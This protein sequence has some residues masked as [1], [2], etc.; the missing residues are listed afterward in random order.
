MNEWSVPLHRIGKR[1]PPV[2]RRKEGLLV[3]CEREV[4]V[5]AR[6][7]RTGWRVAVLQG[8]HSQ[9]TPELRITS[10]TLRCLPA[11]FAPFLKFLQSRLSGRLHQLTA[12]RYPLYTGLHFLR[13]HVMTWCS[14]IDGRQCFRGIYCLYLQGTGL[15][16]FFGG[17]GT[18]CGLL[19]WCSLVGGY[20]SI[21]LRH[22]AVS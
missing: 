14:Y 4:G 8:A 11:R 7:R 10:R 13:L 20:Q 6:L 1:L 3:M 15:E 17:E 2:R 21:G 19:I 22:F 16:V 12:H 5:R 18:Y 9:D